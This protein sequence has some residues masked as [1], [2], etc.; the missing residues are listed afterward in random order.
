MIA[1]NYFFRYQYFNSLAQNR[2]SW[3]RLCALPFFEMDNQRS[4]RNAVGM[5]D[6]R[7]LLQ[8]FDASTAEEEKSWRVADMEGGRELPGRGCLRAV[9]EYR[10]FATTGLLFIILGF[11]LIIWNRIGNTTGCSQQVG[12][13]H[14]DKKQSCSSPRGTYKQHHL[15]DIGHTTQ[16]QPRSYNGRRTMTSFH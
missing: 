13:D 12:G 15:V 2:S 11:Q 5:Q 4:N 14:M 6:R 9:A 16:F 10:W 3:D 8:D 1:F 7:G